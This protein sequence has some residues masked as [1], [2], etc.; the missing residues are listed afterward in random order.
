LLASALDAGRDRE[1]ETESA[2]HRLTGADVDDAYDRLL[3]NRSR[4]I[5]WYKRL[6]RD[7]NQPELGFALDSLAAIARSNEGLTRRQLLNR[8]QRR[9]PDPDSRARRLDAAL[10][11]LEEDGY[12]GFEGERVQFLSFLLR[13]YWKRNHA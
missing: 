7:L 9:E 10:L 8:L 6:D 3:A 2:D 4:F 11:R 5:H 13:D 12:L 1:L